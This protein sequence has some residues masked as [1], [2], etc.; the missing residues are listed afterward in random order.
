MLLQF[1]SLLLF[2]RREIIDLSH[3]TSTARICTVFV[4]SRGRIGYWD[5]R[6]QDAVMRLDTCTRTDL[7]EEFADEVSACYLSRTHLG[8]RK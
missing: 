5:R 2:I 4:S 6:W 3:E 7:S 8:S 1:V